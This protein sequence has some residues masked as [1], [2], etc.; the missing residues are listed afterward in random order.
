MELSHVWNNFDGTIDRFATFGTSLIVFDDFLSHIVGHVRTFGMARLAIHLDMIWILLIKRL[1]A[2]SALETAL[3]EFGIVAEFD[4]WF[5]VSQRFTADITSAIIFIKL[6]LGTILMHWFAVLQ[7]NAPACERFLA[8]GTNEAT[9]M[10]RL[11]HCVQDGLPWLE[12]F[13][14]FRTGLLSHFVY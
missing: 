4:N 8:F 5:S 14:A 9:N 2:N 11:A 12:L 10:P 1:A 13:L 6:F 3:M 7:N